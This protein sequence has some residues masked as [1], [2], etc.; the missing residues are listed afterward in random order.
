MDLQTLKQ[1][2]SLKN[3]SKSI[4]S[5]LMRFPAAV[6]FL[7]CLTVILSYVVLT[8]TD[9]DRYLLCLISFL[10]GGT[11]VSFTT[12]LWGEEQADKRKRWIAEGIA[13]GLYAVYCILLFLTDLIPNRGLPAFTIGNAAWMVAVIVLIPFGSF[14]R[15][16][17]DLKSWHFILSLCAALIVSGVVTGV[18][19]GGLEGLVF[20]TGELFDFEPN[21]KLCAIIFIVC[22]VLLWGILFLAMIPSG[23]RKHNNA[24]EMPSFLTKVVSWL[25]LPLLGCYILVLYVYGITILVQWEL[26]K[27]MISWLVSAVM[28]GY[29]LCYILI[30]PQVTNR[31]SWQSKALTRWLPILIM[32]LLVLMTVGVVRRFM[33]YGVTPPR[34][35]LL[36]LLLWFYAICIVMLVVPCK[37][38][39]WIFLSL[40]A[41]FLLSSGHPLNYYHLC[42][43]ILAEKID[44]LIAEHDDK[45]EAE[46]R[47]MRDC[48]GAEFTSRWDVPE[49]EFYATDKYKTRDQTWK[50][51]YSKQTYGNL[52]PQGYYKFSWI[53]R[54]TDDLAEKI[55][56]NNLHEGV[57]HVPYEDA[58]LLFDTAAIQKA[59]QNKE[60]LLIP[61][62][63]KQKALSVQYICITAYSDSTI[64]V[65]YSGYIFSKN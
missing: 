30:Y 34:L 8:K 11:V 65:N 33:D 44:Q 39:H 5:V 61:S 41:L 55:T 56:E 26:P 58:I 18:M 35:Y 4:Q 28:V 24:A 1:H 7:V 49:N 62:K 17:D 53:N 63:D 64:N 25:L 36:T 2:L 57:I 6:C 23:E 12:S 10:S 48:Y 21:K 47:Y 19:T 37:R 51:D 43:P 60:L 27:G 59:Q 50:I 13:L 22:T 3:I 32:P 54:E 29:V 16:K 40:A 15:E 46:L 52:C 42:R 31:D 38:F 20:G 45:L 14:L 9:P